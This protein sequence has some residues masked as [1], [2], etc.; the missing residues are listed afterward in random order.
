GI[1]GAAAFLYHPPTALPFWGVWALLWV[2]P[3]KW[4][5]G[6]WRAFIPLG[7]AAAVL[8]AVAQSEGGKQAFFAR[9]PAWLE[10]LQR[11]RASYVYVSTWPWET[12]ARHVVVFAILLAACRRVRSKMGTDA[13]VFLVG[14]PA[15][16]LLSMP[17]SWLLLEHWKWAL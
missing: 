5:R 13:R 12:I 4:D 2:W 1:A 14:L 8:V 9:L 17:L 15:V 6:R 3:A 16:G 11:M 10:A 7:I